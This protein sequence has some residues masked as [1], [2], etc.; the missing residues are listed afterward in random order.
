MNKTRLSK[1]LSFRIAS[2]SSSYADAAQYFKQSL[3]ELRIP[4]QP[5]ECSYWDEQRKSW[6][7]EQLEAIGDALGLGWVFLAPVFIDNAQSALD[8]ISGE[9]GNDPGMEEE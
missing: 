8:D 1:N 5:C 9:L 2:K 3:T 4:D 7:C 6:W